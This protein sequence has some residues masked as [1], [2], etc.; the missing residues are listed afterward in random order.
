VGFIGV[1]FCL[2]LIEFLDSIA[3]GKERFLLWLNLKLGVKIK[4][5]CK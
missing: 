5:F 4:G 3:V 2:D 1:L